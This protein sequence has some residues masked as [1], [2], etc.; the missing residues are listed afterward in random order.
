M[1]F[2]CCLFVYVVAFVGKK[3]HFSPLVH[4]SL[5]PMKKRSMTLISL[6]IFNALQSS[7]CIFSW[8]RTRKQKTT[9][10]VAKVNN[11]TNTVTI[12][13]YCIL[14]CTIFL[15]NYVEMLF[16]VVFIKREG[17]RKESKIP[18]LIFVLFFRREAL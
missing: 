5:G 12:P 8:S 16:V 1:L 17:E 2:F 3:G 13:W 11:T 18:F 4:L 15:L 10:T 9:N 6:I 14:D 7:Y